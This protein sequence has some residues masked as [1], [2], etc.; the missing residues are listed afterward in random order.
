ML[1]MY[2]V[3]VFILPSH[4]YYHRNRSWPLQIM[5]NMMTIIEILP[6]IHTQLRFLG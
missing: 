6:P 1:L 2:K 4:D 5:G 3:V